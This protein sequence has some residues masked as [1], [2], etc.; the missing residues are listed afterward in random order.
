M[1]KLVANAHEAIGDIGD[2]ATV[3]MGG[4]GLC[5]IPENLIAALHDKGTKNLTIKSRLLHGMIS[6]HLKVSNELPTSFFATNRFHGSSFNSFFV[7]GALKNS[8]HVDPWRVNTVC[9]QLLRFHQ[10]LHFSNG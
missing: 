10:F 6:P 5:G 4:F 2:G 1:K 9:V 8:F 7:I 3:M